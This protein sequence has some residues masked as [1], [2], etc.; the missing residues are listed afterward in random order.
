MNSL[1]RFYFDGL[2]GDLFWPGIY[3]VT[4]RRLILQTGSSERKASNICNQITSG[5]FMARAQSSQ[6]M[7]ST[8]LV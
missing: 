8:N 1:D 2:F 7:K 6:L 3:P 5:L 4:S